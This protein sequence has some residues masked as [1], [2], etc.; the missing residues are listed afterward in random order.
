MKK[1]VYIFID[2]AN[3]WEAQK[4]KGYFLDFKK[5]T[6]YLSDRYKAT[7]TKVFYYTAYPAAGTRAYNTD[8][9]HRFYTFLEKGLDFC[10]RK[11][12]L[13]RIHSDQSTH[14]DG[15]VEKGNM[16]VELTID[17]V[18]Y[19]KKYDTAIFFTGDSDFLS[20]IKFIRGRGKKSYVFSSRNDVSLE[21]RTGADGYT[22]IL[23]ISEDIW[24]KELAY[25]AQSN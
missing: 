10:V 21:L 23:S 14:E 13:K 12:Q 3:L 16:D 19:C 7:E 20:L 11:K 8:G 1:V 17:V 22:D 15:M 6:K 9:K 24:G 5:L 4:S 18:D 25:R 2:A